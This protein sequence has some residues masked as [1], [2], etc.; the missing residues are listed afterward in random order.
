M[1]Q[2][3]V[4]FPTINE[5]RERIFSSSSSEEIINGLAE[6]QEIVDI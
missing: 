6:E 2:Q 4:E 5:G 1:Q 3:P